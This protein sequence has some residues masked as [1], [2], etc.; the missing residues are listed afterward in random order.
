MQIYKQTFLTKILF[1]QI[2]L[3]LGLALPMRSNAQ[4]LPNFAGKE[5][6][7]N[8]PSRTLQLLQ[9]GR[10][11]REYPVGVGY[12]KQ[13]Q[14]PPGRYKVEKKIINPIWEH[15]YKAAG[16][17]QIGSNSK[18]PLGSRW[19]GFHGEGSGVYGMHGTNE[20][21]SIGR[22]VSH[23]CVR[24]HNSDVEELFEMIEIGTPVNVT[25]DR[26]SLHQAGDKITLEVFPD[27]YGIKALS[28]DKI[29]KEVS[30]LYPEASIDLES[31]GEALK[32][33][34]ESSIYEIAQFMPY[35]RMPAR[36][37]PNVPFADPF[38]GNDLNNV[39]FGGTPAVPAPVYGTPL[40]IFY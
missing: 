19:I 15:P 24:M 29:V 32:D 9:S 21:N 27:P 18:N 17:S 11:I 20:P 37:M 1:L 6:R 16:Q 23:G 2:L 3:A 8:V 31:I 38:Y 28:A 26:F 4:F 12:S 39:V 7:I 40:P 34:S 10:L 25:Y 36:P 14:T 35:S 33:T 5:I 22:F 30:R 13:M